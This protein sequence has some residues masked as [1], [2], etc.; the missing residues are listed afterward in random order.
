MTSLAATATGTAATA[1]RAEYGALLLR[2]GL[3]VMFIAHALLKYFVFTLPGTAQ[4]FGSLGL[5]PVLG[6]AVFAAELVG[7]V[8]LVLGVYARQVALAL[9]P[10]VAARLGAMPSILVNSASRFGQD[11]PDDVVA[12]S[13]LGHYAVNTAAPAILARHVAAAAGAAPLTKR[14]P[15]RVLRPSPGICLGGR[16]Q[17]PRWTSD[18]SGGLAAGTPAE[19]S[20][21]L[22][23]LG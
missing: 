1:S 11:G 5:P 14:G 13:M 17:S 15:E 4:F 20:R 9:V 7:G 2:L 3:G 21:V 23:Q 12:D 8:L 19:P 18:V 10:A 22:G 16:G 6:Y